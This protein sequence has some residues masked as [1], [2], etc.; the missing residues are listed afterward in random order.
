[1]GAGLKRFE[2][3]K[4]APPQPDYEQISPRVISVLGHNPSQFTLNGTNCYLVGQGKKRTLIDTG[5][6]DRGNEKFM[7]CLAKVMEMEGCDGLDRILVTHAHF[8]HYGG[9]D[10]LL[11]KYGFD[12]P[13][14]KLPNPSYLTRSMQQI[15]KRGLQVLLEDENGKPL[16][17]PTPGVR[18]FPA[19]FKKF[20]RV[21]PDE[22]AEAGKALSWDSAG[23][24]KAEM[25]RDY[26][27]IKK[28]WDFSR[29]LTT[30]YN[31]IELRDGDIIKT[32]GATLK[33][34]FTPG[35]ADDHCS[36]LLQEEQCLF[37]G[38]HVLGFGTTVMIN[39]FD[40]M[41]TLEK[42]IG[43][44]PVHLY[45]GH[46]PVIEDGLGLLERYVEHRNARE[47]QIVSTMANYFATIKGPGLTTELL[48]K[49]IY[50]KTSP[51]NMW[52]AKQNI[53]KVL[54]KL[55]REGRASAY[56]KKDGEL[57]RAQMPHFGPVLRLPEP[58]VWFLHPQAQQLAGGSADGFLMQLR[59]LTKNSPEELFARLSLVQLD[60]AKS[61]VGELAD[62]LWESVTRIAAAGEAAARRQEGKQQ[63]EE[64]DD[65]AT[66]VSSN[67]SSRY[68][69]TK[70]RL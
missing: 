11:K 63:V 25:V 57:V 9:V 49:M 27:F 32:E 61:L 65:E 64:V 54:L 2:I 3:G 21:W 8:D 26:P 16:Y 70:A 19:D 24:T 23:R 14:C 66:A 46:G 53:E 41:E 55:D 5:E 62:R 45:P 35:H 13:V 68:G 34:M 39:L 7:A 60:E 48:A 36:F 69:N 33:C 10:N 20:T 1:V 12:I 38:D 42:M 17:I 15:R 59:Q 31:Y 43:V 40:Y 6:A 67:G 22:E 29:R 58:L 52:M 28:A 56:T 44:R 47:R 30:K 37:S 51:E 4:T 50:T 18:A